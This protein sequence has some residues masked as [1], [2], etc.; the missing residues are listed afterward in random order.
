MI[1]PPTITTPPQNQAVGIGGTATFTVGVE[2][3][4]ALQLSMAQEQLAPG[5]RDQLGAGR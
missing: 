3:Q 4:R 1:V 5:G 2:R